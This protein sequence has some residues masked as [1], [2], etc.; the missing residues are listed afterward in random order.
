MQI[1]KV[2]KITTQLSNYV[3]I[4]VYGAGDGIRTCD[5]LITNELHYRL[6]YTSMLLNCKVESCDLLIYD[7]KYSRT[8]AA[9]ALHYSLFLPFT[10][11][12]HLPLAA[13]VCSAN[14][15][16]YRLCYTSK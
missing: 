5:L 1:N 2:K 12:L 6:C 3:V 15:L 10:D 14:E 8:A 4:C 7:Q 11:S 13:L 9:F 16:H